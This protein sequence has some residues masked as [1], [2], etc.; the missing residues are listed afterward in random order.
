MNHM[1]M[2]M[3]AAVAAVSSVSAI[4]AN[5]TSYVQ[6]GLIAQWDGIDN[7]GRG[8]HDDNV[9]AWIDLVSGRAFAL[10]GVTVGDDRLTFAGTSTSY[11]QLPGAD[12]AATFDV[13][14]AGGAARPCRRSWGRRT[15]AEMDGSDLLRADFRRRCPP[16]SSSGAE[17]WG[18]ENRAHSKCKE[19]R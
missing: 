18:C 2:T 16:V 4:A 10:T 17:Q 12:T 7:A 5:S 8:R 14:G 13:A 15:E 9:T 11:G 19:T 1:R 6:N 3:I